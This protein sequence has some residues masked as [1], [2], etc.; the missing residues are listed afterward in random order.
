MKL[1][2]FISLLV[3]MV[4]LQTIQAQTFGRDQKK[5]RKEVSSVVKPQINLSLGTSFTTFYPGMN[6]FS[7]WVAPEISMP[8]G[9]KW[10]VSAGVAYTNFFMGGTPEIAGMGH[11][12]QNYGT[13]YVSGRY[14]INP[15]LSVTASGYKTF[16]LSPVKQKEKVN[17][18]ALDFSN[19]GAA[20]SID[21]KVNDH[22]RI[23]AAFSMEQYRYNPFYPSGYGGYYGRPF[24]P[25]FPGG[26]YPGF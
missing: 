20:T 9:K 14:L 5:Q 21:Y 4:S 1:K 10:T 15:K 12:V 23:N 3:V 25:A 16:N 6:G 8:A 17:P 26:Y 13:F 18:R 11:T 2:L 19:S 24:S 7:S 22:F